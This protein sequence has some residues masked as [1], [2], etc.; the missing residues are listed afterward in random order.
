MAMKS[1]MSI[2]PA[3]LNAWLGSGNTVVID[4]REAGEHARGHIPGSRLMPLSRLDPYALPPNQQVV[5]C[6]ASGC[7]SK[8]AARRLG[9]EGLAHLEGGLAAWVDS[10]F[11]TTQGHTPRLIAPRFEP[12]AQFA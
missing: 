7:R 9:V 11:P 10:G 3:T 8:T 1:L 6:C 12:L 2:D 5:L 4:V